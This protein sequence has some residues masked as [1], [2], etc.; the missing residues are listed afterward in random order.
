MKNIAH[1]LREKLHELQGE[2]EDDLA[3]KRDEFKYHLEQRKIVFEREALEFQREAKKG[4][5][6][7]LRESNILFVLTSPIIYAM[8]IPMVISDIF[9]SVY[10]TIC[11][12]IYGIPKVKR[13]DYV[14]MDRKYL[15]YL[16]LIEKMNCI[17]CEYS[18]GVIA[19]VREVASVTE[20]YWC[21]IKHARGLKDAPPRYYEFLE[22]GDADHFHEKWD[23]QRE[24]CRACEMPSGACT[25]QKDGPP[26]K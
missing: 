8:I 1:T 25:P 14:V 12:P 22:Y 10:Q 16:N 2:I 20:Q 15:A 5:L 13:S 9:V 6:K 26:S 21:P 18:N 17:Y 11:F 24:K 7:F 23:K 4:L 3:A 19:Y